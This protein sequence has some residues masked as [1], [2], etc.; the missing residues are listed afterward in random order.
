MVLN[1]LC[2]ATV[3]RSV[4]TA[5][6]A[7][8]VLS[9][10]TLSALAGLGLVPF[11]H[12]TASVSATLATCVTPAAYTFSIWAVI[13]TVLVLIVMYAIALLFLKVGEVKAWRLGG[14]VPTSS[15]LTLVI[16]LNL[17]V[18]WLFAWDAID[19]TGSSI[20]LWLIAVSSGI[21]VS[22]SANSFA[23]DAPSLYKKS[24]FHFWSGI[25]VIN[26]LALYNTWTA[27]AAIISRNIFYEYE[28]DLNSNTICLLELI[29]LLALFVGWFILENTILIL[30]A[31]PLIIHNMVLLWAAVGIYIEQKDLASTEELTLM[32]ITIATASVLIVTRIVIL[33]YRNKNNAIYNNTAMV[34]E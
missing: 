19:V 11:R 3:A 9:T 6:L 10:V 23:K 33:L 25:L 29:I 32:I 16:S 1:H 28:I 7:A 17:I 30:Y 26:G 2:G 15:L 13:Y 27:I 34:L 21:A 20:I 4:V 5:V 22:L 8:S 12:S 24:K 31:N 14:A 18:G